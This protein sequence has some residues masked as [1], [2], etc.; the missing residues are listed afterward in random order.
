[1]D[2][3]LLWGVTSYLR[4]VILVTK[5][6]TSSRATHVFLMYQSQ[7]QVDRNPSTHNNLRE[8]GSSDSEA[9]MTAEFPLISISLVWHSPAPPSHY[10]KQTLLLFFPRGLTAHQKISWAHKISWEW[11]VLIPAYAGF[12]WPVWDC[13]QEVL[14]RIFLLLA[15]ANGT[16]VPWYF[17]LDHF[18]NVIM[19]T[20]F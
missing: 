18:P 20:L 5:K 12:I 14:C 8:T 6:V 1:M 16:I 3:E 15:I 11:K 17:E 9:T 7:N 4:D 10:L 2:L 19:I 13:F